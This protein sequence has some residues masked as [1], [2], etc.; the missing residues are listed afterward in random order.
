MKQGPKYLLDTDTF[1]RAHR[2]HYR[3]SF[4]PAYWIALIQQH[5]AGS[6]ASISQVKRELL[7]GKDDLSTWV[8]TKLPVSFFKGTEDAKV[9]QTYASI[10]KWVV[11]LTH[12][13]PEAQSH[14]VGSADGWLIA[15]ARVNR[16]TVCSYEVS[17]PES[18]NN[19]KLPDIASQFGVSCES[20]YDMLE[21]LDLRMVLTK[22]ASRE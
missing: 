15:F 2:Q 4:C 18:K 16:Y 10:V 9:I 21:Q 22:R 7:R 1:I 6:V 11:S 20:P 5:N 14:F 3:F 17:A 19:I 12:L 8:K 13:T